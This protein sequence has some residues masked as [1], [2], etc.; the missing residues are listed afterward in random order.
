VQ[1]GYADVAVLVDV[2]M[3]NFVDHSQ[4]GRPDDGVQKLSFY[5]VDAAAK[6]S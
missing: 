2:R 3:P 6:I 4:L 5:V 1:D